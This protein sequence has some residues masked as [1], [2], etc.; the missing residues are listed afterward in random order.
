[1][2]FG[3]ECKKVKRTGFAVSFFFGGLLAAAVPV[4]NMAVRSANYLSIHASPVQILMNANWQLMAMLNVLLA[5][6][7]ACLMYHIE[8]A[9]GAASKMCALPVRESSIFFSKFALMAVM[10]VEILAIETAGI[11]FCVVYWF[12]M[13]DELWIELIKGF[14]YAVLLMLPAG[15]CALLIASACRNMWVS[16]GI[17]VVCIFTATLLPTDHFIL[18]LFPFALPFQMSSG[19][20]EKTIYNFIIAALVEIAAIAAVKVTLL[21][22]RRR[23]G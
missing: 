23:L 18:S 21:K 3:L 9:D 7:G 22:G 19:M 11:L 15:L 10:C 17:S 4:L 1:M 12:E 14:G 6:S 5:A 13:S 8:Y 16:L 2:G 20:P